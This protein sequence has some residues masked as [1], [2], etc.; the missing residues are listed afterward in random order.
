MATRLP[1]Q[2]RTFPQGP[3]I[4]V[5]P[6]PSV[7][8]GTGQ[9]GEVYRAGA[10]SPFGRAL[11]TPELVGARY[12]ESNR[13]NPITLR[14]G[15]TGGDS[16]WQ[17]IVI[18]RPSFVWPTGYASDGSTLN[19]PGAEVLYAPHARPRVDTEALRSLRRGIAYLSNPG[20]WWLKYGAATAS[21]AATLECVVIDA[22]DPGVVSKY[23]SEPGPNYVTQGDVATISTA[24]VQLVAANPYRKALTIQNTSTFAIR[25]GLGITAVGTTGV[26]IVAGVTGTVTFSG[27]SLFLGAVN[28]IRDSTASADASCAY[29]EY[30]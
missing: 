14:G 12:T 25:L 15:L 8:P 5:V 18:D 7:P 27:D 2:E 28:G 6:L 21:P 11:S 19:V 29:V 13:L 20:V 30:V 24:S 22:S 17:A 9:P 16:G 3:L 1:A 4:P 10:A 26:R 23:L